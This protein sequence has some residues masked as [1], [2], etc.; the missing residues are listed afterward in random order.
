MWCGEHVHSLEIF[1]YL[2]TL[3]AG[4]GSQGQGY[5]GAADPQNR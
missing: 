3:F 5:V 2:F 1:L 4:I